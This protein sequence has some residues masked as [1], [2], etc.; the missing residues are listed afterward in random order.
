MYLFHVCLYGKEFIL[1]IKVKVKE[2]LLAK[3]RERFEIILDFEH[4]LYSY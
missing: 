1:N 4:R 2:N 3:V